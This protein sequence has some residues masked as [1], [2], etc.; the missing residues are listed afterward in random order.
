MHTD[1]VE[2]K[3]LLTDGCKHVAEAGG[4]Y[5][6]FD[7]IWSYQAMLR[8]EEFQVWKLTKQPVGGWL[9]TCDDGNKN[10]LVTQQVE[11]ADFPLD[12]IKFF[13]S[14]SVCMLPSEN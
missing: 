14:E 3:Y 7:I 2:L 11:Y 6:L 10:I 5:W 1:T 4:A 8:K 13:L 12:S 9:V